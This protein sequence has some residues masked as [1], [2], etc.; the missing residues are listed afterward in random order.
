MKKVLALL[1]LLGFA[2]LVGSA[3]F[4]ILAF[5]VSAGGGGIF[6]APKGVLI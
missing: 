3:K 2:V 1:A 5:G 6:T 4:A